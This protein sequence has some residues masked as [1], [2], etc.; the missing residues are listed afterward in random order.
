M[1]FR[2]PSLF[3]YCYKTITAQP[4]VARKE[5]A[6]LSSAP[7]TIYAAEAGLAPVPAVGAGLAP[8]AAPLEYRN[9][10]VQEFF[11]ILPEIADQKPQISR[12]PSE[13]IVELRIGE[14]FSGR[15]GVVVQ[16]GRGAGEIRARVAQFVVQRVVGSQ[17]AQTSLPGAHI[18][19]HGV[20]IRE[21]F[22]G[23]IVK[24]RI[25]EQFSDRAFLRA[26]IG[27]NHI[28]VVQPFVHLAVQFIRNE[29]PAHRSLTG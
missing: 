5:S 2:L 8:P 19:D 15:G 3:S 20:S 29:K 6:I 4:R 16:F 26:H 24:R 11:R 27:E 10:D 22:L 18:R 14:K 13:I 17:L 1:V 9:L 21:R 7:A 23:L 28:Y 12:K 25:V